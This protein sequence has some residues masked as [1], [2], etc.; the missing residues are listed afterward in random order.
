MIYGTTGYTGHMAAEHAKALGVDVVITGRTAEK[1]ESLAEH[2]DVSCRVF[3]LK[4]LGG[5]TL[6]SVG[7]LLNFSPFCHGDV[8][9]INVM[10]QFAAGSCHTVSNSSAM[11]KLTKCAHI[12][13]QS[14]I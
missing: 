7:V 3:G 9:K 12:V 8:A 2:F 4:V 13:C 1:Q 6:E 14:R 11:M 10:D 5:E